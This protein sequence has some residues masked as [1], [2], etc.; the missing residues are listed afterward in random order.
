MSAA[1]GDHEGEEIA[2][3][4]YAAE[5]VYL[6]QHEWATCADD[7]LCR[8]SKLGLHL[9]PAGAA[10]LDAWIAAGQAIDQNIT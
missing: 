9:P 2:P 8:R 1:R 5:V 7:I 6:M 10:R 3:G 4:L